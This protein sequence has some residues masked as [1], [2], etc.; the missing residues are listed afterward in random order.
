MTSFK[1]VSPL[2]S[3]EG[4]MLLSVCLHHQEQEEAAVHMRCCQKTEKQTSWGLRNGGRT[5]IHGVHTE[6]RDCA[7]GQDLSRGAWDRAWKREAERVAVC[8][9]PMQH[10]S[11]RWQ[12]QNL[13]PSQQCENISYTYFS[14]SCTPR[15]NCGSVWVSLVPVTHVHRLFWGSMWKSFTPAPVTEKA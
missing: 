4:D 6:T 3:Q 11:T 15:V 13:T 9:L 1:Q 7:L 5:C 8:F 10:F 12:R 14:L 2:T